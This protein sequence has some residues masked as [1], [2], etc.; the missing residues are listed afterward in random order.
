MAGFI[1]RDVDRVEFTACNQKINKEVFDKFRDCCKR[2]GYP[3]NVVIEPFMQ[4]YANGRF[5]ID[6][7]DIRKWKNIESELDIFNTTFNKEI[8]INFKNA[9]KSNGYFI[10]DVIT[11]FME[12]FVKSEV[13]LEYTRTYELG[14]EKNINAHKTEFDQT[15]FSFN[16]WTCPECGEKFEAVAE[17]W[18]VK[19]YTEDGKQIIVCRE[20]CGH[21]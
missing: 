21:V 20:N 11:A 1:K 13:V 3:M 5:D 10:K 18:C 17:N 9:V 4:Q 7:A 14:V 12:I 16:L 2:M 8:Y 15:I 6:S 19:Q